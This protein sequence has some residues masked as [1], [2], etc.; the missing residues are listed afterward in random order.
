MTIPKQER[1][2]VDEAGVVHGGMHSRSPRARLAAS[3][4]SR[5]N[6]SHR[7]T[8]AQDQVLP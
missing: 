5:P 4:R 2:A 8:A 3:P 7:T 6:I 1:D